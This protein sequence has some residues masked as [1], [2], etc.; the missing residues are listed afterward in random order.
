MLYKYKM[1]LIQPPVVVPSQLM[2][3]DRVFLPLVVKKE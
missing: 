2:R 1:G 3:L